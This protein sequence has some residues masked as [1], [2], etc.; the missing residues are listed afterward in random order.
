MNGCSIMGMDHVTLVKTLK[1][2]PQHVRIV[3][4]RQTNN[5]LLFEP[6]SVISPSGYMIENQQEPTENIYANQTPE[7]SDPLLQV[8]NG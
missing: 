3:C 4:A 6:T 5:P 7:H 8:N 1:Q 2:L